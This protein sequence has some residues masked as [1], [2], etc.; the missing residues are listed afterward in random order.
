[1]E[2]ENAEEDKLLIVSIT[3]S[4]LRAATFKICYMRGMFPMDYFVNEFDPAL[5]MVIP[6]LKLIGKDDK[7]SRLIDRIED[8]YQG[9][10]E[11]KQDKFVFSVCDAPMIEDYTFYF[12]YSNS[13]CEELTPDQ[14]RN[15]ARQMLEGLDGEMEAQVGMCEKEPSLLLE[16][17]EFNSKHLVLRLEMRVR[18]QE[19]VPLDNQQPEEDNEELKAEAE[20]TEQESFALTWDLFRAVLF[21][22]CQLKRLFPK[23]YFKAWSVLG[24]EMEVW[25][26]TPEDEESKEFIVDLEELNQALQEKD[27]VKSVFPVR[28]SIDP[29]MM[30]EYTF[31]FRYP[32]SDSDG[33]EE[34][35]PDQMRSSAHQLLVSLGRVI[36]TLDRRMPQEV[37]EV[38]HFRSN[39]C[40]FEL[41]IR[42]VRSREV[43]VPVGD[44][45]QRQ[46]HRQ[47]DELV[48]ELI[49]GKGNCCF[50]AR[51]SSALYCTNEFNV[52]GLC[53]RGSCPLANSFSSTIKEDEGRLYLYYKNVESPNRPKD[54]W[55]RVMLPKSLEKALEKIDHHLPNWP[56]SVVNWTKLR[57]TA[58]RQRQIRAE[59]KRGRPSREL[60]KKILEGPQRGKRDIFNDPLKTFEEMI[61]IHGVKE[62]DDEE[63]VEYV[64]DSD[65]GD[66]G[67]GDF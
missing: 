41:Q 11:R 33:Q 63:E 3:W 62:E 31:S 2:A 32:N 8:V 45:Q 14:M 42:M 54:L 46:V 19:V 12:S 5:E 13:E 65:I 1:M 17:G 57:F 38:G 36:G 26:L 15:S 30:E 64:Y 59:K 25:E 21:K 6:K 29:T 67:L 55:A 16:L 49:R 51:I 48:W 52:T 37:L 44:N 27:L 18:S 22:I 50:R 34:M 10:E 35:T 24:L 61:E 56:K 43:P 60:E 20:I 9:L 28:N 53:D 7:C 39:H 58:M 40:V 66:K 4:L 47:H 23:Q